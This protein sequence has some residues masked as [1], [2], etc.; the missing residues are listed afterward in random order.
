[1]LKH[2]WSVLAFQLAGSDGL[3]IIHADG[4]DEERE[5]PP[6]EP[7]VAELLSRPQ[8]E[9]LSTLVL[10]DEVLMYLRVQAESD[11]SSRGRMVSFF[12]YLTQAVVKVDR[13]AMVASLLASDP[14][15][16]DDFGREILRDVSEVFGRQMEEEVSPVSKEDVAEV[17]RRR[18]FKPESIRDTGAFRPHVTSVVG[19][20]AALDEQTRKE[21]PASEERYLS[22]YPFHP[23]LTEVFYTLGPSLKGFSGRGAYCGLRRRASGCREMG[24]QSAD[25]AERVPERAWGGRSGRG[26]R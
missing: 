16:Y 25:R 24:L 13:C 20:I 9:G 1:M 10:L 11:P 23:D 14:R 19:N 8:A 21:R 22:S 7:F 15:K 4:K 6:A 12:Q 18:F 3:K 17:L 26:R 5:T 2:P